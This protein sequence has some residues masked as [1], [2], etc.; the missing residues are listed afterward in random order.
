M[1]EIM[2]PDHLPIRWFASDVLGTYNSGTSSWVLTDSFGNALDDAWVVTANTPNSV[3]MNFFQDIDL[4]GLQEN[5]MTFNPLSYVVQRWGMP[6]ESITPNVSVVISWVTSTKPIPTTFNINEISYTN[7]YGPSYDELVGYQIQSWT[8]DT[9]GQLM[10]L[11][12]VQTLGV[13]QATAA[14]KLYSLC[15]VVVSIP[16]GSAASNNEKFG[17]PTSV[18]TIQQQVERENDLQ[19]IMRLK[20]AYD[21]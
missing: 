2:E 10:R 4:T 8:N 6:A 18:V 1:G 5:Y 11:A 9:T 19:Y 20:R 15:R 3:G 21:S 13:L 16:A 17:I 7:Q 14:A 12:D